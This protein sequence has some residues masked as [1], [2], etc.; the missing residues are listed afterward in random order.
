MLRN[1]L[2]TYS[3]ISAVFEISIEKS[4]GTNSWVP[5]DDTTTVENNDFS[6][7]TFANHEDII[8]VLS[9]FEF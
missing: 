1:I 2:L 8:D 6:S 9:R 3:L 7:K 5:Y 4:I